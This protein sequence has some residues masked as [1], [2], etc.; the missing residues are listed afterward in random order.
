DFFDLSKAAFSFQYANNEVYNKWCKLLNCSEKD[1]K[2][3]ED[4]PFLPIEFFK[5]HRVTCFNKEKE[6]DFFLSSGTSSMQR[7]QHLVYN[8]QYYVENTFSCFSQFFDKVENY[9]YLCLLPN[10]LEQ[11][12]SSLICMMEAFVKKSIYKQSGFYSH[13]LRQV[14]DILLS[15]QKN[16]IPTILFGVTYALMDLAENFDLH[17]HNTIVFETGGMKGRRKEL[18]KHEVH[19]LLKNRFG[20]EKIASEYGMCELFSQGYSLGD[21]LFFTPKQMHVAIKE[22]N[23]YKNTLPAEKR[24]I[25]NI[26]DLANISSCCF[27]QTGD[28]GIKHSNGGFS[29]LGRMDY[30][31]IRGCNLMYQ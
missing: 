17:L 8:K 31:D 29:I 19:N 5:N 2:T 20:V 10:Y 30:A 13:N 4:I 11:E 27:I 6:E 23:D 24:G 18:P 22:I 12:H 28:L 25:I 3:L 16:N 15:N 21:G 9:A 14:A 7:S 26:I 1:I